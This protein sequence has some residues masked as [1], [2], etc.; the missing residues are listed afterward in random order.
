MTRD[1]Y[2]MLGVTATASK[3]EIRR[4]YQ[5][6]ARQYS[7]DVNL[8]EQEARVLFEEI[9]EAYR[10]LSD[11]MTRALYDRHPAAPDDGDGSAADVSRAS[12]RRGDD[13]HVPVAPARAWY[14]R[15]AARWN[16]GRV[17]RAAAPACGSPIRASRAGGVASRRA[18]ARF[19][20]SCPRA[21]TPARSFGFRARGMP[22]PTEGPAA[23]SS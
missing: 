2:A 8:W 20:W 3:V 22:D 17:P 18:V 6:L 4:A 1:Y 10:V 19:T 15:A 11:P 21:S 9:A 13:V 12:G 14:G 5:R 7:P 23:T 16:P